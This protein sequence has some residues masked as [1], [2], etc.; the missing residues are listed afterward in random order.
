M[1]HRWVGVLSQSQ[2]SADLHIRM[3]M[4]V[5]DCDLGQQYSAARGF[6]R[7]AVEL[8]VCHGIAACHGETR[9]C[10]FLLHFVSNLRFF[11]LFFNFT[12]YKSI[13]SGGCK[14]RFCA[15]APSSKLDTR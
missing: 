11:G 8:A 10:P 14:L 12:I 13:K 2:W 3:R 5:R 15:L 9:N 1:A 4:W 6:S 7:H